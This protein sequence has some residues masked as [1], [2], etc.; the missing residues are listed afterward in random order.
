MRAQMSL[1]M[2]AYIALAG[3]SL[4]YSVGAAHHYLESASGYIS[5]YSY[6]EFADSISTA[7]LQKS[8]HFNI[9]VPSGICNST[10]NGSSLMLGGNSYQLPE[11][12]SVQDGFLCQPG[13]HEA[14]AQYYPG[15]AYI[16]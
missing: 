13:P 12:V 6:S 4:L 2:L 15:Y 7:L 3:I 1:E 16:S 14:D 11:R 8:S 10:I 9:Y 5:S